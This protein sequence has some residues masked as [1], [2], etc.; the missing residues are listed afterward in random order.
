MINIPVNDPAALPS[1]KKTDAKR[2][3][4]LV[5]RIL[6]D[7]GRGMPSVS[8][9]GKGGHAITAD[10]ARAIG[11]LFV[12]KAYFANLVYDVYGR[13]DRL[14]VSRLLS[15]GGM[16]AGPCVSEGDDRPEAEPHEV[17]CAARVEPDIFNFNGELVAAASDPGKPYA[18]YRR[19]YPHK[20]KWIVADSTHRVICMCLWRSH[21][22]ATVDELNALAAG[23]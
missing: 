10:E 14:V 6:S 7:F 21:A 2:R 3:D 17:P 20:P 19:A 4:K 23:R 16:D 13:F 11:Q 22:Q 12:D 1:A 8:I 9:G 18:L 15:G 5:K